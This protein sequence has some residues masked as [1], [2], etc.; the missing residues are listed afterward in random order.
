[1]SQQLYRPLKL[2]KIWF[3]DVFESSQ[4]RVPLSSHE[5]FQQFISIPDVLSVYKKIFM[6]SQWH[7]GKKALKLAR[8]VH[9]CK[10]PFFKILKI[11]L[12]RPLLIFRHSDFRFF[13]VSRSVTTCVKIMENKNS[14]YWKVPKLHHSYRH[15]LLIKIDV[16]LH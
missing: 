5:L 11:A 12:S 6:W 3:F 4:L 8:S 7:L 2:I 9:F 10:I 14:Y 16:A 13:L 1:M 15:W